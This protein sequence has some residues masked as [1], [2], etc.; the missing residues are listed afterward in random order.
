MRLDCAALAQVLLCRQDELVVHNPFRVPLVQGGARV[1]ID[2]LVLGQC[3]VTLLGITAASIAKVA[4]G[5][6]LPDPVVVIAASHNLELVPVHERDELLPDVLGAP[7]RPG[8][9]EVLVAPGV[10]EAIV[11][12][13][14]VDLQ[15]RAMVAFGL[16]EARLL[17]VRHGLLVLGPVE[18]VLDRE[19]GHYRH[20]LV[21]APQVD[22]SEQHLREVRL[23]GKLG[24]LPAEFR[25]QA[26][27]V[28]A[29]QSPQAFHGVDHRLHGWL[30][31][32][33]EGEHV[34]DTH[35]FQQKDDVRE[36]RP[37]DFRHRGGEHLIPVCQLRV[38]AIALPWSGS[39]CSTCPLTRVGLSDRGDQE[40]VH[41]RLGIVHLHL[42]HT[43]V[44]H[45]VNAVD[46]EGCL[47]DVCR[48]DALPTTR[49][50]GL[51]DHG[52][53]FRREGAVDGQ[54]DQGWRAHGLQL[55]HTLM[56]NL[57]CSIDLLLTSE[58]HQDV[59]GGL[60]EVDL[61]HGHEGRL[62]IVLLGVL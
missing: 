24:H 49:W 14:P 45:E 21:A 60:R 41:A 10:G 46:G 43:G 47:G 40:G 44:H 18:H 28:E 26:L 33:V 12:P 8:L 15:K 2:L 34:V 13:T 52:L 48:H 61:Q 54:D 32:E 19:H 17:L 58:E 6:A 59:A 23:H 25:E 56:Q 5:D 29:T 53:H 42:G 31:H 22:C 9:D 3:P 20:D 1:D 55:L 50:G 57:A 7:Q 4:G 11:R 39:A 27:V 36:V 62:H 37:L 51:E 35:R 38:E 16:M 30:V